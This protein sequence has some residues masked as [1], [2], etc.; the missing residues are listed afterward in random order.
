LGEKKRRGKL[1][2]KRNRCPGRVHYS[3]KKGGKM[4]KKKPTRGSRAPQLKLGGRSFPKGRGDSVVGAGWEFSC[5]NKIKPVAG[6]RDQK[7]RGRKD[8]LKKKRGKQ[9]SKIM[10]ARGHTFCSGAEKKKRRVVVKGRILGPKTPKKPRPAKE[11]LPRGGRGS[12]TNLSLV[13]AH[14]KK[15]GERNNQRAHLKMGLAVGKGEGKKGPERGAQSET[16][17]KYVSFCDSGEEAMDKLNRDS[18]GGKSWGAYF[19][20]YGEESKRELKRS[21]EH[22]KKG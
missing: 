11:R 1:K 17:L 15:K 5:Q 19:H 22:N 14:G 16:H 13:F 20:L 6:S 7:G 18:K 9:E 2:G 21:D 8:R 10:S 3:R 4:K 12:S